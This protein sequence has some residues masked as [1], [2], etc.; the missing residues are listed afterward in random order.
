[1]NPK[2]VAFCVFA[3]PDGALRITPEPA[4]GRLNKRTIRELAKRIA[5]SLP[6]IARETPLLNGVLSLHEQK[7]M[8]QE[9]DDE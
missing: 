2:D 9:G 5:R 3:R 6:R 8:A 4:V 7:Q 1:M